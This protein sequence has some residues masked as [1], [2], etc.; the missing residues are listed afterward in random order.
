MKAARKSKDTA[1][2]VFGRFSAVGQCTVRVLPACGVTLV[3]IINLAHPKPT[4]DLNASAP[5][6]DYIPR[7]EFV[8]VNMTNY[9]FV[10]AVGGQGSFS[11]RL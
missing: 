2:V 3:R 1:Y 5:A 11:I 6:S 8:R 9:G 7:L 10:G 4:D